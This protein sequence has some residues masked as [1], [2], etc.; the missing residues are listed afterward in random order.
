MYVVHGLCYL[1]APVHACYNFNF[2]IDYSNNIFCTQISVVVL[3]IEQRNSW[4]RSVTSSK[5]IYMKA[6]K[7]VYI[8]IIF[9]IMILPV[10]NCLWVICGEERNHGVH[11]AEKKKFHKMI[12]LKFQQFVR[13]LV[14]LIL[15]CFKKK[16]YLFSKM[17]TF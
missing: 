2:L 11:D 12:F 13:R 14:F 5:C 4:M 6:L 9:T 8:W 7:K 10:F 1:L 17:Y 15:L 16:L 3:N